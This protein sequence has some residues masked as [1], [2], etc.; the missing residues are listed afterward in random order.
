M[1]GHVALRYLDSQ[2]DGRLDVWLKS[3]ESQVGKHAGKVLQ[4]VRST[5]PEGSVLRELLVVLLF[6]LVLV[7]L[8]TLQVSCQ[9]FLFSRNVVHL[10]G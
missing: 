1:I 7:F 10:V 5:P 3:R 8:L 9:V 6:L 4:S 2:A